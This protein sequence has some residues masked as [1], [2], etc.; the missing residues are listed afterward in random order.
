MATAYLL[1]IPARRPKTL[2]IYNNENLC[3]ANPRPADNNENSIVIVVLSA[4]PNFLQRKLV[5]QTYGSIRHIN[6]VRIVAVVFM[7]GGS[8]DQ[9]EPITDISKLEAERVQYNDVIMGDFVDT[10]KNLTRKSIMSYDWLV[11]FCKEADIVVKTDDDVIL[12]IFK[13]TEELST[14][15]P[16]VFQSSYFWCAIH[17][18]EPLNREEGNRYYVSPEQ[19]S[20]DNAPAHCAGVGYVT[21]MVVIRRIADEISRSFLN[22]VCPQEDIFMTGIVTEKINSYGRELIKYIDKMNEWI[23]YVLENNN[24]ETA[25]YVLKLLGQSPN[26]TVNFEEFRNRCGTR[27]FYLIDHG[28]KFEK[29]YQ[30][31]WYLIENSF[32]NEGLNSL[33]L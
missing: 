30:R 5:R 24:D 7:V 13:L 4:R 9:V 32:R 3:S 19:Y 16:T 26:D 6:N 22:D 15:T 29:E 28:E 14:W 23:L 27:L 12:N 31:L 17:F 18:N 8:D 25:V 2:L 20:K 1:L 11:S 10:Y 33:S 21:P